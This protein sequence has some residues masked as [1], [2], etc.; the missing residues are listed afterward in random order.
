[1][2]AMVATAVACRGAEPASDRENGRGGP[3]VSVADGASPSSARDSVSAR[4]IVFIGTSLTA[5][6]GLPPEQ[7][8]PALLQEKFDAAGENYLVVNRGVSGETSAGARAR[9]PS[10]LDPPADV[11]VI[12]TGANDGLR[13]LD[14]DAMRENI[15]AIID[16][17]RAEVPSARIY[18]V[19]MEAPPNLGRTY[20]SA[21]RQVFPELAARNDVTLI[22][23][24][25]DGVIADRRYNQED[26]MHPNAA[27]ARIVAENVWRGLEGLTK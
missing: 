19:A 6:L 12:E 27:G 16:G 8:Y 21:F 1:M 15:Q 25:L 26:G 4:R 2:L 10:L 17:I 24:L 23:F 14:V 7:S 22:P 13:G 11:Y 3:A 18:L 5:G 20:T 9:L